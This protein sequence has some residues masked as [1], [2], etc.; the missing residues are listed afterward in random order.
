[1]DAQPL[2]VIIPSRSRP[3]SVAKI[4]D[5][6]DA[7]GA[8]QVAAPLFVIDAD[9][10]AC[11][12]YESALSARLMARRRQP[13]WVP[14]VAKLNAAAIDHAT[15][16][17]HRAIAF[18]GDDH[19]PRSAGWAQDTLAALDEMGT[20][21]VYPND[22]YQGEKLASSWAMTTDIIKQLGRMVPAPVEHL[23]CDNSIMDLGRAVGRLQYL[24]H[25]LIEHM[26]PVAGKVAND[27]QY[28]RVNG[29]EQYR[30]DRPQYRQWRDRGG[31]QRDA[32]LI[33]ELLKGAPTDA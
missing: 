30:K 24:P 27:A 8:W 22:G 31:L 25:V 13:R 19:I 11:D 23:Y 14:M 5:A 28:E 20:G 1:M 32:Q 6:Y 15:Y 7:T 2:L 17:D 9:D 33:N 26:H 12:A 29:R 21:I 4:A 3:E 18:A 16:Y 10:P